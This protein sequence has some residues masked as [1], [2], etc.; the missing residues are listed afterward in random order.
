MPYPGTMMTLLA[1]ERSAARLAAS[2]SVTSPCE[3]C[4]LGAGVAPDSVPKPPKTTFQME[5]FMASH[6]MMLRIAPEEPTSAP[7]MMSALFCR[8]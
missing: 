3:P 5:R 7:V 6:M 4:A 2:I 1:F 8:A